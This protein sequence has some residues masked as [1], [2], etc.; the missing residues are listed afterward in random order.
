[1]IKKKNKKCLES[2]INN[3]KWTCQFC[4]KEDF[5]MKRC[6][7]CGIATY[8]SKYCQ[9]KHWFSHKITCI[10][11]EDDISECLE[12]MTS[13]L[14]N[15]GFFNPDLAETTRELNHLMKV[16]VIHCDRNDYHTKPGSIKYEVYTFEMIKKKKDMVEFISMI[17]KAFAY[18]GPKLIFLLKAYSKLSKCQ[19][20]KILVLK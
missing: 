17:K 3:G 18:K 5:N 19:L 6:S 10:K 12:S 14:H 11:R 16:P 15:I 8:C 1:M 13:Y 7:N 4:Q 20:I 9:K 2:P